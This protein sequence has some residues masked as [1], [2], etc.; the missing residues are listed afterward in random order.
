M[1]TTTERP[2][3][4]R[5]GLG[6]GR[7]RVG[8]PQRSNPTSVAQDRL[9][10]HSHVAGLRHG[11]GRDAGWGIE[12][13]DRA[14]RGRRALLAC[15]DLR[16]VGDGL[17]A[18]DLDDVDQRLCVVALGGHESPSGP[19]ERRGR[20]QIRAGRGLPPLGRLSAQL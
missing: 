9:R 20:R 13:P 17:A 11:F 5:L 10:Q 12:Q 6:D 8:D 15:D 19:L 4:A 14:R 18:V 2:L 3:Q 1:P 16:I 7:Q